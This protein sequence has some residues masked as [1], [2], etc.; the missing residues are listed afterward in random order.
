METHR[1]FGDAFWNTM[2][3]ENP[4]KGNGFTYT[5]GLFTYNYDGHAM[6]NHGGDVVGFHPMTAFFPDDNIAVVILS[7]DDNFKRFD[8]LSAVADG[9][10]G[11]KYKYPK[12]ESNAE[13]A[14]AKDV[15]IVIEPTVLESYTGNYELAPGY[16]VAITTE[17]GKLKYTQLWDDVTIINPPGKEVHHFAI[18]G[19]TLIFSGFT[20]NKAAQLRIVTDNEDSVFMRLDKDPDLTLYDK[21]SGVFF[22]RSLNTSAT[23]YTQK[24]ILRYKLGTDAASY[25]ASPPDGED[26]FAT[27]HGT[28]S[29][30]KDEA[31]TIKGFTLNHQR[32]LNMVFVKKKSE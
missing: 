1:I 17:D 6:I 19:V 7:N 12:Q 31:G 23:F 20:A 22:C 10:L 15:A 4:A 3:A 14:H 21:Y 30:L 32:A 29:F 11:K 25:V 24:G 2:V 28:V 5:K 18:D 27:T 13:N 8:I 9:L 16:V 26:T